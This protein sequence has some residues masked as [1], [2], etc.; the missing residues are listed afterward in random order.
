MKIANLVISILIRSFNNFEFVILFEFMI[1]E[2]SYFVISLVVVSIFSVF[3]CYVI[4]FRNYII[5][6]I[7]PIMLFIFPLI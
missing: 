2:V 6:I 1:Y 5:I 4:G 3:R 7:C